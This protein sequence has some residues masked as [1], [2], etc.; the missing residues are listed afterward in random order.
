MSAETNHADL[1]GRHAAAVEA[2]RAAGSLLKSYYGNRSAL[3]VE[4][5]GVNDFVSRADREAEAAIIGHLAARFPNDG[6]VGEETG[7]SGLSGAS[8]VWVIDPLDGTTNF[9]KGAHNWCV[10]IGLVVDGHLSAGVVYDP[11]RDEM[12]ESITGG[13]ARLNGVPIRVGTVADPG[14]AIIGLGYV[15]RVGT[16]LFCADTGR[17][18]DT[19]LSFRQIGAGALMLAYVAAGRVDAYFERHMWPWDA[20]GGLALIKE[21][22]GAVSSYPTGEDLVGGGAV[23]AANPQLHAVLADVVPLTRSTLL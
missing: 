22:G 13:G 6:F 4:Q 10:S 20:V 21:A 18:L 1:S 2:A 5:K 23:L 17:L 7:A 19:G 9:L 16:E 12:F 8:A 15:P 14:S 11:V 3:V